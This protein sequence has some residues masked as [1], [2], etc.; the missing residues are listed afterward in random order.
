MVGWRCW[1]RV[2]WPTFQ[3]LL[4][5][6]W[7]LKSSA[8]RIWVRE[9]WMFELISFIGIR[10]R[11]AI[12]KDPC[13]TLV[14]KRYGLKRQSVIQIRMRRLVGEVCYEGWKVAIQPFWVERSDKVVP[15]EPVMGLV[16]TRAL[17]LLKAS[18]ICAIRSV[19]AIIFDLPLQKETG[20]LTMETKAFQLR[21][22]CNEWNRR[23]GGI[24]CIEERVNFRFLFLTFII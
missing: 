9:R 19:I 21:A 3:G 13:G 14:S 2:C 11:D 22:S 17:L 6:R 8:K 16:H 4:V 5:C 20:L 1:T 10:K 24:F 15:L 18:W 23:G 7:I 12:R